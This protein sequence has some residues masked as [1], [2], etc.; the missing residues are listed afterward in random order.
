[1]SLKREWN[2]VIRV[3]IC[4][5]T[6]GVH[7]VSMKSIHFRFAIFHIKDQSPTIRRLLYLMVLFSVLFRLSFFVGPENSILHIY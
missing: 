4:I 7:P 1:M 5:C 6:N 2:I 3:H